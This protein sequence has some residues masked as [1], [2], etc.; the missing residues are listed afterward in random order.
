MQLNSDYDLS[1]KMVRDGDGMIVSGVM[2]G[3]VIAQNQALILL[4]QK[5]EIKESPTT[6][7]GID[8]LCN[9]ADFRAWK[10]EITEQMEADGQRISRLEITENKL[11]LEA[12][13]L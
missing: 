8:G 2:I 7:A 10:R 4:C 9:D 11:I 3:T 12:K 13:Y 1:V 5:G 6:G